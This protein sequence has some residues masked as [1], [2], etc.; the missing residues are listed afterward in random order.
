MWFK[1]LHLFQFMEK[2]ELS[3]EAL[4]AELARRAFE[5][6]PT[7]EARSEG[8]APPGGEEDAPLVHASNGMLLFC[9]KAEEKLV[10]ASVVKEEFEIKRKAF[11]QAQNRKLRKQER[12]ELKDD[13]YH[14]LLPR[15]FSKSTHT[16]AYIDPLKGWLVVNAASAKKAEALT[17]ALR[18]TLGSLKIQLPEVQPIALLLTDWLTT[19]AYPESIVIQDTC[20]L[21]D[22][23]DGGT[24]R[25][26]KQNLLA[27]DIQTLLDGREVAQLAMS[28]K[29]QVSFVLTEDFA[30]KSLKFLE[31]I[32][33]QY[34]D[35]Y[36]ETEQA[37]FDASFTIMVLTLRELLDMLMGVFGKSKAN[38]EA[39]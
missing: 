9:L 14:S 7:N 4:E 18:K 23:K 1:N 6:C 15:A 20:V 39:A 5:P 30:V 3:A 24:I 36:A 38:S 12:E 16:H 2:F 31:V 33:D 25:C 26:S 17:V 21:H 19:N 22:N 34:N 10:P 11:E 13:V 35:I 27:S 28:W 29:E 8:W 32:Q 37:R